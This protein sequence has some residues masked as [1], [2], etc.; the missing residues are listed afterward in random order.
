MPA[1][2]MRIPPRPRLII[3]T[4][5]DTFVKIQIIDDDSV[6]Y[7]IL[8]TYGGLNDNNHLISG[9]ITR[10]ATDR[11]DNFKLKIINDGGRFLNKFDGGEV[12]KIFADATDATTLIFYG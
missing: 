2:S 11:L 9:S 7:T 1:R 10:A 8:D 5:S 4:L 6:T 3:P 12:V